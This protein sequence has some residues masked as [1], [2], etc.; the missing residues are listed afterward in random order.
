MK[1]KKLYHSKSNSTWAIIYEYYNDFLLYNIS[2][3][4]IKHISKSN[5]SYT[6][7]DE[8]YSSFNGL[9]LLPNK[10]PSSYIQTNIVHA[11]R[12]GD[13]IVKYVLEDYPSQKLIIKDGHFVPLYDSDRVLINNLIL[14]NQL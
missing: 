11:Y 12:G 10:I 14:L 7:L 9:L 2:N 6:T 4:Y 5:N 8:S 13:G 3:G 1:Y